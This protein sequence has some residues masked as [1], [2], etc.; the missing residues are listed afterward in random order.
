M[1]E[2]SRRRLIGTSLGVAAAAG[3]GTLAVPGA[4]SAATATAPASKRPPKLA[5]V[6]GMRGDRL[7]NEFW[8]QLDEV[9]LYSPTAEFVDA[10]MAIKAVFPGDFEVAVAQAWVGDRTAGTYPG[11][12]RDLLLPLRDALEV[13][14]A[15]QKAVHDT[16]YPCDWTAFTGAMIDF[17]QG[18]LYD[19]RRGAGAMVHMM[20]GTPPVGYH[21][22]HAFN[23]GFQLLGISADFWARYDVLVGLGWAL[24]STAKPVPDASTNKPLPRETVRRLT[25]EWLTKSPSAADDAFMNFPYPPGIS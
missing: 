7:A 20:N 16:Y 9:A 17:G 25:R 22:W 5:P 1:T 23:R 8:Y 14:S 3:L 21:T 10:I 15:V 2:M 13:V 19:P 18:V 11:G 6:P 12:F 4:A 24:Q